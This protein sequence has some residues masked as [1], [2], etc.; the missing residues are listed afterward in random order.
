MTC[1]QGHSM[2]KKKK[3]YLKITPL[4]EDRG[5]VLLSLSPTFIALLTVQSVPWHLGN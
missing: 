1:A 3:S 4:L 5:L 2:V